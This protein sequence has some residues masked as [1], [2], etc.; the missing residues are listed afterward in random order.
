MKVRLHWSPVSLAVLA[1][2]SVGAFAAPADL[3]T[4]HAASSGPTTFV[5]DENINDIGSEW[6]PSVTYDTEIVATANLYQTLTLYNDKT[7]ALEPVLATS[8]SSSDN[9]RVWTFHLRHNV[10]FHTGRLM[11]SS[12]VKASIERTISLNQGAAYEWGPVTSIATPNEYTVVFTCKYPYPLNIVSSSAYGAYIYDTQAAGAESLSDW[13][14]A[15]HDAGTGPYT[16]QSFTPGQS[17]MLVLKE[18]P[19]Y[20][21][22][23]KGNHFTKVVFDYTPQSST[24]SLLLKS[25]QIS[26]VQSISP[27]I[28]EQFKGEPGFE[29]PTSLSWQNYLLS[30]N[31]ASGPLANADFRKAVSYA[32]NYQGIVAA[33]SGAAIHTPGIVTPGLL[34]YSSKLP[35]YPYSVKEAKAYLGKSGYAHKSVTLTLSI[36]TGETF[37]ETPAELIKSNLAKIGVN[38]EI[39]TVDVDAQLSLA[40]SANPAQRPDMGIF[41]WWPDYADAYSWFVNLF[42]K[43]NPPVWNWS[44]YSDATLSK[45]INDVESVLAQS[46]TKGADLYEKMQREIYADDATINLF[47]IRYQRVLQSYVKGF[48]DNPAY[49]NVVFV[50]DLTR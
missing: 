11:T 42:T 29:T 48:V 41:T 7:K 46:E 9:G 8:W 47:D 35:E 34:G 16:V 22:G 2:V 5:Y 20:W 14:Q 21:G 19:E 10:R 4:A 27:Q 23:W 24:A 17:T 1:L 26:Y 30:F 12:S 40:D 36:V 38:V 13:F 6:D 32:I 25:G 50:Y 31:T 15:G 39:K 43:Q 44:G 37:E 18:F 3:L 33:L 28:W 49:P 45:Q